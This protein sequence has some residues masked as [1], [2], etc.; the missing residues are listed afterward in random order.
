[1]RRVLRGLPDWLIAAAAIASLLG[2]LYSE[3]THNDR[4]IWTHITAVEAHQQ[5]DKDQLGH[6]QSQVDRLVEWAMGAK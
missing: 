5:S 6:I 4:D 1:M 3:T 2:T